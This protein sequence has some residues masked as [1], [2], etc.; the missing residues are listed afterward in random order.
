MGAFSGSPNA[1]PG[2]DGLTIEYNGDDLRNVTGVLRTVHRN[3]CPP[4]GA[5]LGSA[6][7]A[8]GTRFY[9]IF[10]SGSQQATEANASA[11]MQAKSIRAMRVYLSLVSTVGDATLTLRD[12]AADT[13][14][15][16]T[17]TA[18]SAA[19]WYEFSAGLPYTPATASLMALKVVAGGTGSTTVDA[20]ETEVAN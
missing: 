4:G 11:R 3:R 2:V 19:G 15:V 17:V 13:A 14:V 10:E 20:I 5:A 9:P 1:R 16:R 12:D 7:P 6:T 8:S 18:G